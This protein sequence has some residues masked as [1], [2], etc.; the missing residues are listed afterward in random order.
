MTRHELAAIRPGV[1]RA[2]RFIAVLLMAACTTDG[3]GRTD[4]QTTLAALRASQATAYGVPDIG[5]VGLTVRTSLAAT[6]WSRLTDDQLLAWARIWS[7]V[8]A[9]DE[10]P[11]VGYEIADADG[12][13]VRLNL[14]DQSPRDGFCVAWALAPGDGEAPARVRSFLSGLAGE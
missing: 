9:Q 3:A 11:F 8:R 4:G 1:I 5:D 13:R 7:A 12:S 6:K 14:F 10:R 2:L